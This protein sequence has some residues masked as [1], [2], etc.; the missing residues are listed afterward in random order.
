MQP[1]ER[2]PLT[3]RERAV[4]YGVLGLAAEVVFTGLRD[5]AGT[6]TRTPRL[7][8]YS[9]LWMLPIY[10]LIAVLYEPVHDRL[11]AAPRWKRA[12]AY[13]AGFVAVEYATGMAIKRLTGVVP[14]DYTGQSRYALPGGAVRL[15]YLPLWGSAG[16]LLERVD[17]AMRSLLV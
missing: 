1:I 2:R 17:D 15:D 5:A 8:G 16:L 10:A 13:A 9:Y 7:R 11:R 3:R 14:W 4:T 12:A 6:R